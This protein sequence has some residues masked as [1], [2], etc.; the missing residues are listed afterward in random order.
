MKF[1]FDISLRSNVTQTFYLKLLSME[2]NEAHWLLVRMFAKE[3]CKHLLIIF[4][5]I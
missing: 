4:I 2:M 3:I 5:H 1:G